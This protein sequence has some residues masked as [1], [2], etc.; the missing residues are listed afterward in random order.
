MPAASTRFLLRDGD[1]SLPREGSQLLDER[2]MHA[3]ARSGALACVLKDEHELLVAGEHLQNQLDALARRVLL[4][5]SR[6]QSLRRFGAS[7]LGGGS[8]RGGM[9]RGRE[10]LLRQRRT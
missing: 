10:P 5:C 8:R 3:A 1:V 7:G 9:R 2:R 4:I 6:T